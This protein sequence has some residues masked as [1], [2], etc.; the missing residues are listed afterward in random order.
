MPKL[1]PLTIGDGC[2]LAYRLDGPEDAPVLMLSNSIGTTLQMWDGQIEALSQR[3]RVL[4]YDTRGHGASDAPAGPYSFDRM[5]RDV[6][7]LLDVL[8]IDR[9]SFCGLSLG[10]FVAQWLG[11]HVPD[12]VERLIL[13]NTSSYL[14]PADEWDRQIAS[15]LAADDMT[16]IAD[17]FLANWFPPQMLASDDPAVAP[18]RAALLHMD[19]KGFAG[20]FAAIRDADMRRTIQLITAPT[21]VIAGK[22][23]T[24]TLPEHG[25]LIADAIPGAQLAVLPVVHLSNVERPDAFL[26]AVLAFLD[27][28][29]GTRFAHG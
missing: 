13:A 26:T 19:P 12:R 6:I 8:E 20:C 5:G 14:G 21:L 22:H 1:S 4:R 29:P 18:F 23:D 3:Y 2:R 9:V 27:A 10:G 15:V 11:V 7:E 16:P 25:R 24:V 28:E 17:T